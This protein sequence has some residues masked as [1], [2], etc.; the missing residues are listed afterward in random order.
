MKIGIMQPYFMP[1]IGYWQLIKEVDLYVIFDDVNYI[2]KG[3]INRN[4]ILVHDKRH[5]FTISLQGA[6][7]NKLINEIAVSDDFIKFKKTI[8]MAYSKAPY[9]KQVSFLL[10]EICSFPKYNIAYFIKNSISLVC[11]YLG[12]N[13]AIMMSS[14][15]KK[16]NSLKGQDKILDICKILRAD[17]YVNAIGGR[18]LYE[19]EQFARQNIDLYFLEPKIEKYKQFTSDFVDCLSIIDVLMFNSVEETNYLLS[20]YTLL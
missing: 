18:E 4:N 2:K 8:S 1:Y 19:K 12:I 3:W 9:Y 6:S 11:Q 5:L 14:A 15:I 13:T 7:Q 17:K 10:D 16:D 20:K